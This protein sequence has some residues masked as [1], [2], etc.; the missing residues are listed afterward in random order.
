[1]TGNTTTG[2]FKISADVQPPR[3][4][5]YRKE[6]GTVAIFRVDTVITATPE[7]TE[8]YLHWLCVDTNEKP[9]NH[10]WDF[11]STILRGGYTEQV[12]WLNEHDEL[13]SE[14]RTYR[15]GDVNISKRSE[16]HRVIEVEPNTL[17]HII[18][19]QASE[20]NAWAFLDPATGQI[21]PA[22]RNPEF[23]AMMKE[24]NPHL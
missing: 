6:D 8:K 2:G 14:T 4:I 18:C 17:T 10:P 9:H 7:Y 13:Q 3:C 20:G 15:A 21:I 11:E 19:G 24:V 16:F 22:T 12:F 5:P 23:A 1:M